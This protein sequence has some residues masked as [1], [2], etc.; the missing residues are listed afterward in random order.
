MTATG[1]KSKPFIFTLDKKTV[2]DLNNFHPDDY[3]PFERK[4]LLPKMRRA[5]NKA[6][7]LMD[8]ELAAQLRDLL[9][10]LT[11]ISN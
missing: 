3:T 8:F 5:M 7:Q 2:L 10:L 1:K 9:K 11:K 4:A 6:A